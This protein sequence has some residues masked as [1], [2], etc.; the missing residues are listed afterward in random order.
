M[1]RRFLLGGKSAASLQE[2]RLIWHPVLVV[3]RLFP[4]VIGE[5]EDVPGG[6]KSRIDSARVQRVTLGVAHDEVVPDADVVRAV[7]DG[8]FSIAEW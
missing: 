3:F 5:L 2:L 7:W 8:E 4:Q 1:E 6:K